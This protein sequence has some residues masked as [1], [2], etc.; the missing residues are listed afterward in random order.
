MNIRDYRFLNIAIFDLVLTFIIAFLIHLY[1]WNYPLYD[2]KK[3]INRTYIQYFL[4][5][6]YIFITFIGLGT[7]FHYIFGRKSA[8]SHYLGFSD[9]PSR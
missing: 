2:D 1:M 3:N 4:S 5:L 6:I 8:L 9:K 7:L